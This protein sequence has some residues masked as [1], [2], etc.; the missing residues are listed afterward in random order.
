MHRVV[1]QLYQVM[2]LSMT[3]YEIA[4][5]GEAILPVSPSHCIHVIH[6]HLL[7]FFES[8]HGI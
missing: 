1:K 7:H 3:L 4:F 5:G 2:D 8:I 6:F